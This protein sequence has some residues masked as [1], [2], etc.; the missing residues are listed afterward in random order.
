MESISKRSSPKGR[1]LMLKGLDS[2]VQSYIK[3]LS[4]R[5]G[6]VNT[7]IANAISNTA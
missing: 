6:V 3:S 5:E 4:N 2:V 7:A 1:P